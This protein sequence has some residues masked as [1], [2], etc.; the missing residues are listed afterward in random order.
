MLSALAPAWTRQVHGVAPVLGYNPSVSVLMY[1]IVFAACA[2]GSM[3]QGSIG[4]GL[5]LVAGA[6]LVSVDPAFAPG[7]LLIAGTFISARHLAAEFD[8]IDRPGLRTALTGLPIGVLAG[9][10]ILLAI[11]ERALALGIGAAICIAAVALL[12]GIRPPTSTTVKFVGGMLTAF[13][14][15]AAGVP[16]P[17]F[18][19]A[20]NELKP[21]SIRATN[22]AFTVALSAVSLV[23]LIIADRFGRD[24][25]VL[26]ALMVPGIV[27]GLV[28]ARWVRPQLERPWFRPVILLVALAGGAALI[29]RNL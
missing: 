24:E 29:V 15:I 4:I 12:A 7:P 17:P 19:L 1:L 21:A 16:G 27:F 13:C 28:V 22:G 14:G 20:F 23:V 3:V 10:A 2:A 9:L 8:A 25:A 5:G 26:L 18:V 6:A 11:D